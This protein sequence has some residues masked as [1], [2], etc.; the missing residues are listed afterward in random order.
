MVHFSITSTIFFFV[1]IIYKPS[2]LLL[3]HCRHRWHHTFLRMWWFCVRTEGGGG[4]VSVGAWEDLFGRESVCRS[5]ICGLRAWEGLGLVGW[6]VC[7]FV[8]FGCVDFLCA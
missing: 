6:F 8:P 3:A 1:S 7:L 4:K 5:L 2:G